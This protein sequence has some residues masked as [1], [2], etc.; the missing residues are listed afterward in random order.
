MIALF[1]SVRLPLG[2]IYPI[3]EG[4]GRPT[5][6]SFFTFFNDFPYDEMSRILKVRTQMDL[7]RTN[8]RLVPL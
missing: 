4:R 8:D 7:Y 5:D 6:G 3:E 1:T 2:F